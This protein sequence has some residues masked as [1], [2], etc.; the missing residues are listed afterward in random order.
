MTS[1][2][3]K[4]TDA[5]LSKSAMPAPAGSSISTDVTVKL[6][7]TLLKLIPVEGLDIDDTLS[8]LQPA[9]VLVLVTSTA[10]PL[11]ALIDGELQW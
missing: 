1:P 4:V 11:T 2:L 8:K 3:V 10:A 7:L 6:P 9:P 5:T